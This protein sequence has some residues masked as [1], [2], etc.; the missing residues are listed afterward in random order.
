MSKE[1]NSDAWI[2][3]LSWFALEVKGG[4]KVWKV[5]SLILV[6]IPV[7][8]VVILLKLIK[9]LVL[10]EEVDTKGNTSK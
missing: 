4:T 9:L 8:I 10:T 7:V 5:I 3:N 1:I 6:L 2:V